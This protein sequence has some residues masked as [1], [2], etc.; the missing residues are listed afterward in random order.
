MLRKLTTLAAA[1]ALVGTPAIVHANPAQALSVS[2]AQG[3]RTGAKLDD[4]GNIVWSAGT[5]VIAII[6][7]GVIIYG[8]LELTDSNSKSP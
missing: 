4:E 7:V 5:I 2:S 8:I 1:A 6:I 3:E